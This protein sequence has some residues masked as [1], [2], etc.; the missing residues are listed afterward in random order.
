M[1]ILANMNASVIVLTG[2]LSYADG[3]YVTQYRIHIIFS[4]FISSCGFSSHIL[5][6]FIS[7]LHYYYFLYVY[8]RAP[9]WDLWGQMAEPLASKTPLLTVGGK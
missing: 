6:H 3:W 4:H 7:L 5:I 8:H 2:D 9:Q 1:A